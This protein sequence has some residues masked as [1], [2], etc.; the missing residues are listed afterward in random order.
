MDYVRAYAINRTGVSYGSSKSFITLEAGGGNTVPVV[1]TNPVSAITA[2]SAVCGGNVTSDGGLAITRRGICWSTSPHPNISTGQVADDNQN[3]TGTYSCTMTGLTPNTTYY[4]CAFAVNDEG[5][6]YGEEKTFTTIQENISNWLY[7]G[8]GIANDSWGLTNGGD[9]EWA[10]MFPSANLTPYFGTNITKVRV[11]IN[12]TGTY[13]MR[14]YEGG[15]TSPTTLRLSKYYEINSTGWMI[16]L[17]NPGFN[18][19]TSANLWV[20]LSL[21][22]EA[23]QFPRTA[24][25]GINE[26]NARWAKSNGGSWHDAFDHNGETDLCWT[27]QVYVTNEEDGEKGLEY[28]LPLGSIPEERKIPTFAPKFGMETIRKHR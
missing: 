22:Y 26:P 5:P 1:T 28:E 25:V 23:G 19:N 11:Y 27:I 16:L 12:E 21:S 17:V 14:I 18:I 20:S 3:E 24:S 13:H 8:D 2:T 9:D 4:V 6:G 7:Y 15:T 10:V